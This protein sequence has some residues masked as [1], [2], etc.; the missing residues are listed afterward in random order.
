MSDLPENPSWHVSKN[1]FKSLLSLSNIICKFNTD[2]MSRTIYLS[3]KGN[4]LSYLSTDRDIYLTALLPLK[5]KENVLNV[6]VVLDSKQLLEIVKSDSDFIFYQWEDAFYSNL[7]S[8]YT[9]IDSYPF[10]IANYQCKPYRSPGVKLSGTD[11]L[12]E[13]AWL[14]KLINLAEQVE[15]RRISIVNGVAY[16]QYLNSIV[17]VQSVIPAM[18]LRHRDLIVLHNLIKLYLTLDRQLSIKCVVE[19]VRVYFC[20]DYFEIA[21][22]R[23]DDTF[24]N[25]SIDLFNVERNCDISIDPTQAYKVLS[26]LA[27]CGNR[28]SQVSLSFDGAGVYLLSMSYKGI[29]SE[30]ILAE[31]ECPTLEVIIHTD[32]TKKVFDAIKSHVDVRIVSATARSILLETEIAKVIV[33]VKGGGG[34]E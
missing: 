13:I 6:G 25:R 14:L 19:P 31:G 20:S 4:M 8:G 28:A 24:D 32:V 21:F 26:F 22:S 23:T 7:F 30:F 29:I 3:N 34:N 33:K 12:D 16:G 27:S 5:S 17:A 1:Q 9:K 15:D 18:T 10:E 11:L 2:L